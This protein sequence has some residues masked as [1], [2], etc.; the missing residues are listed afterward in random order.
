MRSALAQTYSGIEVVVS[1]DASPHP[2]VA[3]V[4]RSLAA[5]D[6]RVRVISQPHNLGHTA[7]YRRVLE[8][9]RGEFFMWLADDDWIE[10]DYVERCVAVLRGDPSAGLVCGLAS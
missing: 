6:H 3:S 10:P 8:A 4:L 9:A 2:D 1:D 5:V 7:N